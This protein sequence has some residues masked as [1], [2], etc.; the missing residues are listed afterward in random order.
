M[1]FI[2]YLPGSLHILVTSL[3]VFWLF[4]TW[5]KIIFYL[6]SLQGKRGKTEIEKVNKIIQLK[7]PKSKKGKQVTKMTWAKHVHS[8]FFC[9]LMLNVFSTLFLS[10]WKKHLGCTYVTLMGVITIQWHTNFD[11]NI[12]NWTIGISSPNGVILLWF[13]LGRNKKK[14][15]IDK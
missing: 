11:K 6:L 3:F 4:G 12:H 10:R 2:A 9:C 5:T 1:W 13:R 8:F 14:I 15:H 7:W